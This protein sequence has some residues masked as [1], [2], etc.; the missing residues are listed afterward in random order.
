MGHHL[1]HKNKQKCGTSA[2]VAPPVNFTGN[3]V[4]FSPEEEHHLINV[5][6]QGVGAIIQVLDGKGGI[7]EVEVIGKSAGKLEGR[8][9]SL[10]KCSIIK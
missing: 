10:K 9:L 5:L 1:L 4:M 8:I 2:F 6:R 7:Y 3:K